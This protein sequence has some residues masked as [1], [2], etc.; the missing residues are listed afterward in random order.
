[1]K[2]I[3]TIM[4]L[5]A[6]TTVGM[7]AQGQMGQNI[8]VNGERLPSKAIKSLAFD[9]DNVQMTF[10]DGSSQQEELSAVTVR[11]FKYGDATGDDNVTITDAVGIVNKILG[12][13]SENF[14]EVAADVNLDNYIT[15]TDAVGVVNIIL[16]NSGSSSAPAIAAPDTDETDEAVEP[17]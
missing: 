10:S 16:N 3:F 15:I 2:R 5:S 14:D 9:G 7:L 4:L 6:M 1:M 8:K 17:A 13:P 12:N 11:L